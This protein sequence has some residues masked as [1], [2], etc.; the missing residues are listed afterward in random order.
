MYVS[1]FVMLDQLLYSL[2]G[3]SLT[4]LEA[5]LT[6]QKRPGRTGSQSGA[7][8]GRVPICPVRTCEIRIQ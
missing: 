5:S 8:P 4:R 7:S 6:R 1:I 3:F 2:S